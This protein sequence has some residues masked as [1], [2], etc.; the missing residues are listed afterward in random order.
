M[1]N[2]ISWFG[3]S[4]VTVELLRRSKAGKEGSESFADKVARDNFDK[5]VN[6]VR[7]ALNTCGLSTKAVGRI[8][9]DV[10]YGGFFTD[11]PSTVLELWL[12]EAVAKLG[13]P[14]DI[15]SEAYGNLDF[16]ASVEDNSNTSSYED[17]DEDEDEDYEEDEDEDEDYEEVED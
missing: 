5:R 8:Q 13:Q 4:I 10:G 17:E 1:T 14:L 7:R 6:V 11:V 9:G 3:A 12:K 15:P 2:G 16:D